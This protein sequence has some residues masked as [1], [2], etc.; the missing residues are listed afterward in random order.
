MIV[1]PDAKSPTIIIHDDPDPLPPPSYGAATSA[2]KSTF[3]SDTDSTVSDLTQTTTT[4]AMPGLAAEVDRALPPTPVESESESPARSTSPSSSLPPSPPPSDMS[5]SPIPQLA[6]LPP[7]PSPSPNPTPPAPLLSP[8]APTQG[9]K[10]LGW[11]K[12]GSSKSSGPSPEETR[13]SVLQ[14][15]HDLVIPNQSQSAI[16]DMDSGAA[17]TLAALHEACAVHVSSKPKS[18]SKS[19]SKSPPTLTALLQE[20]SIAA[21]T[22]LYW[23]VVQR[24]NALLDALLRFAVPLTSHAVSD[25]MQACLVTSDQSL[26]SALR[27][28]RSPFAAAHAPTRTATDALFVGT[29]KADEIHV[30]NIGSD[31]AFVAIIDIAMWLP[32]MRIAGRLAVDFIA[33]G[34]LWTLSFITPSPI[35][36]S[37]PAKPTKKSDSWAVALTL[38]EH[39]PPTWVDAQVVIELPGESGVVGNNRNKSGNPSPSGSPNPSEFRPGFGRLHSSAEVTG[40]ALSQPSLSNINLAANTNVVN[41]AP[42]PSPTE[43]ALVVPLSSGKHQLAWRAINSKGKGKADSEGSWGEGNEGGSG[44]FEVTTLPLPA[45]LK[46]ATWSE[47]G[48]QYVNKATADLGVERTGRLMF[49]NCQYLLPDGTLRI[50]LGVRLAKTETEGGCVIC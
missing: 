47:N 7:S 12:L 25:L 2:S 32:R 14:A 43:N 24:R 21:H 23:A 20:S 42:P 49:D 40:A 33:S 10:G 30:R 19:K 22:P 11:L 4:G 36:S 26:F 6:S 28:H 35:K 13:Q 15:I 16:S 17:T 44:G 34:R 8:P 27:Q 45:A 31:G 46:P 38:L 1:S 29:E 37:K 48:V 18:K 50:Q 9:R 5:P 41:D 3:M 39:S